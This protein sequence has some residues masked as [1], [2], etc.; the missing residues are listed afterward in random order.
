MRLT[1]RSDPRRSTE[2]K[3]RNIVLGLD[4][5]HRKTSQDLKS[6]LWLEKYINMSHSEPLGSAPKGFLDGKIPLIDQICQVK[7]NSIR[8]KIGRGV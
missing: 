3:I 1:P 4:K 7:I 8:S 5:P 2:G 6:V